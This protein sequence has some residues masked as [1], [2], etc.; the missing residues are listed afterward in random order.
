MSETLVFLVLLNPARLL[1]QDRTVDPTWLHRFVPQVSETK[2]DLSS[3]TC[4]YKAIFGA[5][6]ADNR[7]LRSVSHFGEVTLESQGNC[8]S[9]VY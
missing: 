8:Q 1:A 5:G 7:I 3:S 9:V 4:H 2:I 6:D